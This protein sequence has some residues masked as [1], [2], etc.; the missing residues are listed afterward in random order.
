[1]N[2]INPAEQAAAEAKR[3]EIQFPVLVCRDSGVVQKYEITK[4]PHLFIIDKKGV[5][6]FSDTFLKA[7]GIKKLVDELI[8]E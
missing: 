3:Y 5:I 6:R 1:M 8:K 7:D 2:S 4:L